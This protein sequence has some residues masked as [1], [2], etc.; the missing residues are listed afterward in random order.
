MRARRYLRALMP[1]RP[2]DLASRLHLQKVCCTVTY[3]SWAQY[4][5]HPSA[6]GGSLSGLQMGMTKEADNASVSMPSN[7]FGLA[8]IDLRPMGWCDEISDSKFSC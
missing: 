5:C 2:G 1:T 8:A 6:G 3:A 7:F 4:P